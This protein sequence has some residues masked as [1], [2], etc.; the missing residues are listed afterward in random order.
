MW[1]DTYTAQRLAEFRRRDD[2][3][4]AEV[5]RLIRS[6][7]R[8]KAAERPTRQGPLFRVRDLVLRAV[9]PKRAKAA[10]QSAAGCRLEGVSPADHPSQA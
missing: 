2:L 3:R 1:P 7:K 10:S 5:E 6:I 4:E 8:A 9:S